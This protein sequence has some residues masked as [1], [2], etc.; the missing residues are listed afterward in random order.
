MRILDISPPVHAGIAVWPGD[1]PFSVETLVDFETGGNLVLS[2]I[3]ST[4]HLGAHADGPRHYTPG[5]ADIGSRDVARY[6]GPCRVV[7]VAGTRGRRVLPSD[8]PAALFEAVS[9]KVS[10]GNPAPWTPRVLL[11]TGSFPDPDRWNDDFA[12]LSPEL[13]AYLHDR[14]VGLIGID[15]P[16]I[17]PMSSKALEAHNAVADR[18]MAVLEGLVLGHVP[19]GVYTLVAL[20]L[21]LQGV[22]AS[23]VRAVLIEG[24]LGYA[25][26]PLPTEP[27]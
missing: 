3:R 15:T 22:D 7:R 11:H 26:G 25:G 4:V 8:L 6:L 23:P 14:G 2:T 27:G 18:D 9:D 17:D 12:A 21:R 20:P 1:T 16:S 13:V 5:G 19:P 24:P 10:D